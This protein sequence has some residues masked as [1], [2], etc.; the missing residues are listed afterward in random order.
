MPR[1]LASFDL[2]LWNSGEGER[3]GLSMSERSP[4]RECLCRAFSVRAVKHSVQ[5]SCPQERRGGK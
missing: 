4:S 5:V 1:A 2:V 3:K